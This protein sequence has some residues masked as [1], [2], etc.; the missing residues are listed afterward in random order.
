MRA[1]TGTADEFSM[2][3]FAQAN[4]QFNVHFLLGMR[5]NPHTEPLKRGEAKARVAGLGPMMPVV[6]PAPKSR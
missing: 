2:H 3:E 4:P 6:E 1:G 5:D